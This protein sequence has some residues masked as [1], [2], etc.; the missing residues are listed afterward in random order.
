MSH[1]K[2]DHS[3]RVSL[4]YNFSNGTCPYEDDKCWFIHK[5]TVEEQKLYECSICRKTYERFNLYKKH[6][7][8]EH[9]EKVENC[10]KYKGGACSYGENCWFIHENVQIIENN[11]KNENENN[12]EN[13]KRLFDIVEKFTARVINIED[14]IKSSR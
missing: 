12:D 14:M 11:K 5:E 10:R 9:T 4:C 2:I 3:E 13:M 7:K 8:F 1:K 6:M